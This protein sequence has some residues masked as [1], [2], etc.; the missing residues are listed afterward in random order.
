MAVIHVAVIHLILCLLWKLCENG[1]T[2]YLYS[3]ESIQC[4]V[5]SEC[6]LVAPVNMYITESGESIVPVWG[7]DNDNEMKIVK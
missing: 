3:I 6:L 4:N 7:S 1:S 2:V 5:S